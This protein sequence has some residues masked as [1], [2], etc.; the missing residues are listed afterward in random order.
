MP[1]RRRRRLRLVP[2]SV[3]RGEPGRLPCRSNEQPEALC[4]AAASFWACLDQSRFLDIAE[5]AAAAILYRTYID[6]A[7]AQPLP[8][9]AV[10]GRRIFLRRSGHAPARTLRDRPFASEA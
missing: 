7:G 5:P 10:W 4:G 9:P 2:L 1:S 3:S 6:G 8:R